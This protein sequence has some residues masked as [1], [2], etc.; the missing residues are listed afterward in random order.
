MTG[1]QTCALPI[2]F[3]TERRPGTVPRPV[4]AAHLSGLL[5]KAFW[6]GA[7]SWVISRIFALRHRKRKI[8]SQIIPQSLVGPVV[9]I[10]WCFKLNEVWHGYGLNLHT[11]T[12]SWLWLQQA[13][14][15]SRAIIPRPTLSII[16]QQLHLRYM[17]MS[18]FPVLVSIEMLDVIQEES[19][20]IFNTP[21][22]WP[23]CI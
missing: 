13:S 23:L 16:K 18:H 14:K 6:R 9:W 19:L 21:K 20:A 7:R 12:A 17:N 8:K 4:F 15:E 11:T 1:V 22:I 2:S 3:G 5:V 10:F